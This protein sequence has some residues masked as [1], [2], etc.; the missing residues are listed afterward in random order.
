MEELVDVQGSGLADDGL[1][2]SGRS[3]AELLDAAEVL[4]QS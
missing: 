3:A 1:Q 2:L 4:Q